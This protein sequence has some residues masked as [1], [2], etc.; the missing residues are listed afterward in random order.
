M[1]DAGAALHLA[2]LFDGK[3]RTLKVG[4]RLFTACGPALL[5]RLTRYVPKIFLDLKFHDIPQT[6]AGAVRAAVALPGVAMLTIH[7]S[8]GMAMMRA[9]GESTGKRRGRPK[10]LAVTV[11]TSMDASQ[12]EQAGIRRTVREQVL[13]LARLARDAGMDGVITSPLEVAVVRA[14]CG[15][16]FLV[17]VPGIRP[18]HSPNE[19]APSGNAASTTRMRLDD[20]R[21]I[22]TPAAALQAGADYL[23][24]GRP[25]LDAPDPVAAAETILQEMAAANP[26]PRTRMPRA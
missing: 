20:Q 2:R 7:A 23:V 18:G 4:S 22:A 6:V 21:R 3:I 24:I 12:L 11:L 15:P 1:E 10:L 14:A 5:R 9:A 19:G 13:Y 25:I 8:G 26:N 17:V 16:D